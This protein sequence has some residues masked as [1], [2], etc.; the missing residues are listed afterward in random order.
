MTEIL[1]HFETITLDEMR[2]I[3]LMNRI[4][5]KFVTTVPVL[6][7]L[8][9]LASDEYYVQQVDGEVIAPYY[10][11][12]YDTEDC[13]MYNRHEVGHLERQKLRVRSYL[14]VGINYLEVKTKNNH[15]RTKKKRTAAEGFDPQARAT[16]DFRLHDYDAFIAANLHYDPQ[17]LSEHLENRFD[18]ITLVNKG[19]TERLTI[20]VNLRF[21]NFIT[22]NYRFMGNLVI[23]ELKRDGHQ[24]SPILPKLLQLRIHPHG[25]SK[26]CIG[27][28][29]T[30][31]ALR[32]NRFK[33]RL[34]YV[35][36]LLNE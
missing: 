9:E 26:Y 11:L 15:G 3:R 20:D 32:R 16:C 12:Y 2:D 8:L 19:K 25:F 36:K 33:P 31:E 14:H 30:N 13:A 18:R 4:D 17:R 22:D 34:H 6:R 7:R 5:T 35:Q 24:P 28:A 29:L 23:I 10:T 1:S 21:H 27:S